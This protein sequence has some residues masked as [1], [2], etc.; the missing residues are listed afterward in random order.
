MNQRLIPGIFLLALAIIAVVLV[1]SRP[2]TSAASTKPK[3]SLEST[4]EADNSS[5]PLSWEAL[6]KQFFS[7]F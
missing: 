1:W 5:H 7:K 2:D 4:A 6:P 3:E